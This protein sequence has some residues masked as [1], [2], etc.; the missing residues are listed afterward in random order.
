M[1]DALRLGDLEEV[2]LLAVAGG[3]DSVGG[4]RAR[5]AA[6]GRVVAPGALHVTLQRLEEKGCVQSWIG[7]PRVGVRAPRLYRLADGGWAAVWAARHLRERLW[8][9]VVEPL[10]EVRGTPEDTVN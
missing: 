7:P 8:A 9:D 1:K 10:A 3:S 5:L 4:V 2:V 6:V